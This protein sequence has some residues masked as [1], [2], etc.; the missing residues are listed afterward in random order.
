MYFILHLYFSLRVH[1]ALKLL[2]NINTNRSI[3]DVSVKR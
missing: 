3:L 2:E 1:V